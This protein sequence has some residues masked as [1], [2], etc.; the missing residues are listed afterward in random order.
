MV[1]Q[2]YGFLHDIAQLTRKLDFARAF[3]DGYLDLQHLAADGGPSKSVCDAS[4][5]GI[6]GGVLL[7]LYGT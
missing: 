6:E 7:I 4:L 3:H 1:P 5:V 2:S